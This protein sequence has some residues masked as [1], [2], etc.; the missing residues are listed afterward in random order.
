MREIISQKQL[1]FEIERRKV[2][3][4]LTELFNSKQREL[5]DALEEDCVVSSPLTYMQEH[6]GIDST[7][8]FGTKWGTVRAYIGDSPEDC[9]VEFLEDKILGLIDKPSTT[10]NEQPLIES[11]IEEDLNHHGEDR[12]LIDFSS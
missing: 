4:I 2:N 1:P 6:G 9:K 5:E 11:G 7:Y 8:Y 10:T 12:S 3:E